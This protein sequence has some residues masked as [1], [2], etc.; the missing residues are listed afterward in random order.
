[1][2]TYNACK[3]KKTD[4]RTTYQ[5]QRQYF[6]TKK[7][8]LTCPNKLFRQH[9]VSQL[10]QWRS[11]GD[12]IILFADHNEHTYNRPLG[13]AL[14][15]TDGLGLQEAVLRHTGR[16]TGATFFRGSK[17]IDRLWVTSDI[18]IANTCVMPFGYG[19]GDHRMFVLDIT[20]ESLVGKTPTKVVRPAS[21]WLNSRVPGC[22]GAYNKSLE[23]NI[24][25]HRLLE[26]LNET[27]RSDAD[28]S[29]KAARI[30][31]IDSEGRDYMRHAE[32]VC[33]KIKNCR[34]PYL[35][36]AAIWIRQAQVY[37]LIICWHKGKIR[38]KGNLK[39]AARRCN[40]LNPLGMSLAE[41]LLRVEEC[42]RECNF[43]QENGRRFQNK[44]LAESLRLAQ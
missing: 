33:R 13:K 30:N 24:V 8:D 38:N 43:F 35:P 44:H 39:R 9:L 42:K 7:N 28:A 5:R 15:N 25:Q 14:A 34:I 20:M 23:H 4:L 11:D 3:N 41:V 21:R 6:I 29:E 1:V 31:K 18:N 2:V 26:R 22:S 37:Y 32:K 10:T 19:I 16:R 17:P 12:R 27:H 40:I 36:E